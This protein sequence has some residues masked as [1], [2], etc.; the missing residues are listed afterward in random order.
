MMQ[1]KNLKNTNE[2]YK[3][4]HFQ[5]SITISLKIPK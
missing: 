3:N 5:K 4:M 1:K 2:M